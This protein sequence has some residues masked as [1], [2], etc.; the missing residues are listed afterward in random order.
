MSEFKCAIAFVMLCASMPSAYADSRNQPLSDCVDIAPQR[1][2]ARYGSQYL[3]VKD[4]DAHYRIG[5]GG[6]CSA[7]SMSTQV[8]IRTDRQDNRLCPSGTR[9]ITR[10]DSCTVRTVVLISEDEYAKY[11]RRGR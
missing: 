8:Q 5:F 1:Q 2:V 6:S 4:G 3:L 9:I 7:I 10:G 11:A